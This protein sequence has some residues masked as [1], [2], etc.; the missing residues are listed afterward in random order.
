MFDGGSLFEIISKHLHVAPEPPSRYA[1]NGFP[2]ELDALVLR[3]LEK[4]PERRVPDART[5]SRR[6]AEVPVAEAWGDE[7]AAAWWSE[8]LPAQ[9]AADAA[10]ADGL[11]GASTRNARRTSTARGT[12]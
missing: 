8:H 4:D 1:P 7:H 11:A 5:L 3:L 9:K 12:C 2:A 10:P 6:L